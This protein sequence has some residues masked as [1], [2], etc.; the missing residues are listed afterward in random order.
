MKKVEICEQEMHVM[1]GDEIQPK[2]PCTVEELA[3][4]EQPALENL[5][6]GRKPVMIKEHNQNQRII[7]VLT[8]LLN[9][10]TRSENGIYPASAWGHSISAWSGRSCVYYDDRT[11]S[12]E[13]LTGKPAHRKVYPVLHRYVKGTPLFTWNRYLELRGLEHVEVVA[14]EEEADRYLEIRFTDCDTSILI[15]NG[16]WMFV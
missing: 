11:V 8:C 16:T 9:L 6:R 3:F 12:Y 4:V 2:E 7:S 15:Q 14:C 13:A 10:C 5:M 1:K